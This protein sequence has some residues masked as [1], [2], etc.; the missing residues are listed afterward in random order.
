VFKVMIAS[1]SDVPSERAIIREVLNEWNII[2][3]DSRKI[4]LLS[5]GWE[6]HTS[7]RMG[8]RPQSIIN[9]QILRDCDLLV[10]AFW[11]KIGTPTDEYASG[12]VEEIEEH[13]KAK[14]P[15]MLYFSNAPVI[16][17][18]V[19]QTQYSELKKFKES[20]KSKG[21]YETYADLNDFRTKFY[22]HLQLELNKDEYLKK[23]IDPLNI[24]TVIDGGAFDIPQ[25]SRE[26]QVLLKEVA[27]DPTGNI[28]QFNTIGGYTVQTN[29]HELMS[30]NNPRERAIWEYAIDELEKMELIVDRNHKRQ[31]FGITRK[32]Y[33]LAELLNP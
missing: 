30:G 20:C 23:S 25:L 9:K 17:D 7:P 12:T 21:L 18:S 3:A 2:N 16:L 15:V 6:T 5:I 8:D 1:P 28:L 27:S 29:G 19:D 14:K 31:V 24:P 13:I 26:A 11:T 4:V 10:G 22:R 32:G 33:E